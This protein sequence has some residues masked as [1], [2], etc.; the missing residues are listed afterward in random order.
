MSIIGHLSFYIFQIFK[1]KLQCWG[2]A[3][4]SPSQALSNQPILLAYSAKLYSLQAIQLMLNTHTK[5]WTPNKKRIQKKL[6][7][8][9][10]V[11]KKNTK[12]SSLHL[13][14]KYRVFSGPKMRKQMLVLFLSISSISIE[15]ICLRIKPRKSFL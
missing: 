1:R 12:K 10:S 9:R 13:D 11:S 6:P 8:I 15:S 5:Y 4:F 14:N 7:L 2:R 3:R